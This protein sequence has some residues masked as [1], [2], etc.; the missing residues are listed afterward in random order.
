MWRG[1]AEIA[2]LQRNTQG[3]AGE[4]RLSAKDTYYIGL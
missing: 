2:A 4:H 3:H 1:L